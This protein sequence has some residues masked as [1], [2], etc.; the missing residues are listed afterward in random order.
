MAN[1]YGNFSD[2]VRHSA[3]QVASIITTSGFSTVDFN[4]WPEFSK[5]IL[6]VLMFIGGCAGSTAGGLKVSR[7]I[8]MFKGIY[9][10]LRR[11][12]HPRSVSSVRFEGKTLEKATLRSVNGY[13]VVYMIVFFAIM[14]VIS[15]EPFGLETAFTATAACFNNVGPGLGEVGPAGSFAGFSDLSTWILSFAMLLGRLEIFPVLLTFSPLTW[16]KK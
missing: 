5:L 13:V 16:A 4:L 8:M 1:V 14:L 11:M 3:F 15:L 2:V 9:R 12:I 6:V 10:D 7:V